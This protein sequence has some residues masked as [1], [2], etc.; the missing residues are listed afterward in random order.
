L[1]FNFLF[2]ELVNHNLFISYKNRCK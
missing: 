1:N 2:L